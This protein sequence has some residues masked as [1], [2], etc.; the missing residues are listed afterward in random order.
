MS[1]LFDEMRRI[2]VPTWIGP[3][4]A[5]APSVDMGWGRIFGGQL[6]GQATAVAQ[7]HKSSRGHLH[8]LHAHFVAS[9]DVQAPVTY[10]LYPVRNGRTYSTFR[11]EAGQNEQLIAHAFLSF[12]Q[13]EDGL[14]HR[15]EMPEV[16]A[17]DS[18]PSYQQTLQAM[19]A[20]LPEQRRSAIS[21]LW[22][23]RLYQQP[24]FDVRPVYPTNFLTLDGDKPERMLWFRTTHPL[25]DDPDIHQQALIWI[26]DFP[27]LGTAL[28]PHQIP[29]TSRQVKLTSLDHSMWFY[30]PFRADQWLLCAIHSPISGSG[31]GM[32]IAQIFRQDGVMV[33]VCTQEGM[34]RLRPPDR[35]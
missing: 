16:P 32:T 26:S 5:T 13:A 15:S 4:Q 31:R 30:N 34:M 21:P 3:N 7:D 25:P 10:H 35:L 14:S 29:P 27:M 28:Q 24:A 9:G 17:P 6:L 8:S 19:V 12:Q 33:A 11:V 20:G 2:L 18:L 22:L 1:E 23:K